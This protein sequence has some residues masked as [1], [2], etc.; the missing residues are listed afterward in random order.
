MKIR[1]IAV[2]L[3]LAAAL[4]VPLFGENVAAGQPDPTLIGK[5]KA[6][7]LLKEISVDKFEDAA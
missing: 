4:S 6:K 5:D 7:Q 1:T 3:A 2:A